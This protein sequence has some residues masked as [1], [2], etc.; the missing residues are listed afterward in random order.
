MSNCVL[1][2][3][4]GTCFDGV[5]FGATPSTVDA[6]EAAVRNA[7]SRPIL[8]HVGE[9]VFN[10]AMSGYAEV[11][12][13]PSYT[14]QIVAMTYPHIGNY[15]VEE[16]WSESGPEGGSPPE[17]RSTIGR[18]IKV[19][20]FVVRSL[21]RGPVPE[22]RVRLSDYLA[23][24]GIS[25]IT[26]VDTRA[27][28]LHLRDNGTQNGVICRTETEAERRRAVEAVHTFPSMEGRGLVSEVGTRR[29]VSIDVPR[30]ASAGIG[31][32]GPHVAI[33]DCGAKAN[34]IREL[35]ALDCRLTVLPSTATADEILATD[36]DAVMLSNGPG[37][38]A[39]L[40]H[41]VEQT[42]LLIGRLPVLGIC[43]GHQIIAEAIGGETFKMKFGHHGVNHPVRDEITGRVFVTSQN[44]GFSVD[45]ESLPDGVSVWFRNAN[46]GSIEGLRDDTRRI[47][48]TQFHPE[49]APGPVDSRWIFEAFLDAIPGYAPRQQAETT[50]SP[51]SNRERER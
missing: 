19:A 39:V 11:L 22:G 21:Y 15:G 28:T 50:D 31:G 5:S 26:G 35:R 49:S 34:I 16:I 47:R 3:S 30:S 32:D 8:A 12:T 17:D 20:G 24:A 1:I 25:G 40:G 38:P 36:P 29:T 42:R 9:V 45:E 4:D 44:H 13:D 14:G 33:Y 7:T 27:L 41:Q 10:T 6:I 37:D 51:S 48:S 46:D 23:S 18:P 2:L 43:L